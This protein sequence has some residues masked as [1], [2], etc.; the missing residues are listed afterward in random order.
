MG[1]HVSEDLKWGNNVLVKLSFLY[2]WLF[3]DLAECDSIQGENLPTLFRFDS[4]SS[5]SI[6]HQWKL[7]KCFTSSVSLQVFILAINSL[8]AVEFSFRNNIETISLIALGDNK[9][10]FLEFDLLHSINNGSLLILIEIGKKN[11]ISN[12][13]D[14]EK[15]LLFGFRDASEFGFAFFV[16]GTEDFFRDADSTS[17]LCFL[18]AF[19]DDPGLFFHALVIAEIGGWVDWLVGSFCF[20]SIRVYLGSLRA[21]WQHMR[22]DQRVS[23]WQFNKSWV[24]QRC[25]HSSLNSP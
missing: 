9:I 16:K 2:G 17:F 22:Q 25:W 5:G 21:T 10:T 1:A 18:L 14:D 12:Q 8:E 23:F 24:A 15:F 11:R 3:H 4:G 6:V 13:A 7:S 19:W 20:D